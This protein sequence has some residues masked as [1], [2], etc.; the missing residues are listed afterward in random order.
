MAFALRG[1]D[2]GTLVVMAGR[3]GCI[4]YAFEA[5]RQ[6]TGLD[7]YEVCSAHGWYRHA[8]LV[9]WIL[10]LL[11]VVRAAELD[12]PHPKKRVRSRPAGP[13]PAGD[14]PPP[15]APDPAR[16]ILAWSYRQRCYQ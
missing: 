5:A 10:A 3:R 12:W 13:G 15:V 4:E 6:E 7:D 11:A 16:Y 9:L 2:P 8:T 14:P 1:C